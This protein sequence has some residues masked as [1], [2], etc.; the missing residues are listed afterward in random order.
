MS[1]SFE[2]LRGSLLPFGLA[3]RNALKLIAVPR[4]FL[5]NRVAV[6]LV[7]HIVR[8][9]LILVLGGRAIR[10]DSSTSIDINVIVGII[11][12][13]YHDVI[14]EMRLRYHCAAARL[15]LLLLLL[16]LIVST[17]TNDGIA[18]C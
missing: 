16:L 8:V 13:I 1:T 12:V 4:P 2:L 9:V 17:N 18:M 11:I 10:G 3:L 5:H 15:V 7:R 14:V 6:P